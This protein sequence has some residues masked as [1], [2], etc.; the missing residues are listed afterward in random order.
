MSKWSEEF[1][2]LP[3]EVRHVIAMNEI[4]L[5]IQHLRMEKE[6]LKK[7]YNQSVAEI[8]GYIS[9]L[10]SELRKGDSHE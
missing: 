7:R 9:N 6:R 3:Y 8:D 5:R 1:N 2:K 10:Q 4:E